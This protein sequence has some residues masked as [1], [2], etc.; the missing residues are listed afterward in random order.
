MRLIYVCRRLGVKTNRIAFRLTHAAISGAGAV[1]AF[2]QHA[3]PV[4]FQQ[5]ALLA[6][7]AVFD[8]LFQ[9]CSLLFAVFLRV[10][11]VV[12]GR[13]GQS[14]QIVR[15]GL[16]APGGSFFQQRLHVGRYG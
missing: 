1:L 12:E 8:A 5:D 6:G 16:A 4:I 11:L 15:D 10:P 14:Q 7:E 9:D 13:S 3:R 2:C